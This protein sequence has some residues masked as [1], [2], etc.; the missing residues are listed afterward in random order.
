MQPSVKRAFL[1]V[2]RNKVTGL[3]FLL[4]YSESTT[5]ISPGV[6]LCALASPSLNGGNAQC[7]L[8]MEMSNEHLRRNAA[9]PRGSS[10]K[11]K[12]PGTMLYV[13]RI[14]NL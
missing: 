14:Y 7:F 3:V 13:T 12:F 4:D 9:I 8:L 10:L 11:I 5:L 1:F 2:L 6:T